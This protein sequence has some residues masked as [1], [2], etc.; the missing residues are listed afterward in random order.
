[1]S[2]FELTAPLTTRHWPG[3]YS[4]APPPDE[5]KTSSTAGDTLSEYVMGAGVSP[6]KVSQSKR[7]PASGSSRLPSWPSKQ[8]GATM[9]P[10]SGTASAHGAVALAPRA[11]NESQSRAA[12]SST[13]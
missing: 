9:S 7:S 12:E 5:E 6:A 4:S 10:M 2:D 3:E 11:P 8:L 1:M 13:R